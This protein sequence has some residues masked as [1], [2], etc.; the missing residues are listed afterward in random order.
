MFLMNASGDK[1]TMEDAVQRVLQ[2]RIIDPLKERYPAVCQDIVAEQDSRADIYLYTKN[3]RNRG[4]YAV[5]IEVKSGGGDGKGAMS[6]LSQV[7]RGVCQALIYAENLFRKE[8]SESRLEEKIENAIHEGLEKMRIEQREDRDKMRKEQREDR[9]RMLPEINELHH[10]LGRR[11]AEPREGRQ[12]K[13][14]RDGGEEEQ[15]HRKRR[16]QNDGSDKCR[17]L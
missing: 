5:I 13:R 3:E 11:N 7:L 12:N 17:L 16:R 14:G 8:G 10:A 6:T 15:L 2:K 9:D 1:F 4:K